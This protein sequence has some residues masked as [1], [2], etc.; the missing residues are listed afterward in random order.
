MADDI[1]DS[2]KDDKP[3]DILLVED[4]E[5]DIKITVKAFKKGKLKTNL[6][7]VRNGEE[8][9]QFV[10]NEGKYDNKAMYPRPGLVLLD[11]NMPKKDGFIV[12]KEMKS[13][14]RLNFIPVIMLTSSKNEEDIVNSY[15]NGAASY[16][17]KPIS[18][19]SLLKVV[20]NFNFYWHIINKL[21]NPDMLKDKEV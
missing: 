14:P 15:R 20:D 11:I 10:K 9:L 16:I 4:N 18:F 7:V 17:Q 6:Y 3:L 8:A 21:P 12:L 13:D 5:A 19:E 2:M 1:K